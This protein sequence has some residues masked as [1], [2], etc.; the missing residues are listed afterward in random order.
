MGRAL[1]THVGVGIVL[2][3]PEEENLP[4]GLAS[5]FER[6][7]NEEGEDNIGEFYYETLKN[8]PLLSLNFGGV[9]EYCQ[10]YTVMVEE[11]SSTIWNGSGSINPA[12]FTISNDAFDQ[13]ASFIMSLGFETV[14]PEIV[15]SASYG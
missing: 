6:F 5:A 13:L 8:Y 14:N 7:V 15:V 9:L 11:S 12:K 4:E 3:H 2:P 1:T 10:D